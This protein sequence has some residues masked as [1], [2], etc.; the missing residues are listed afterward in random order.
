[1]PQVELGT[2]EVVKDWSK[3][4]QSIIGLLRAKQAA[5]LEQLE[6]SQH[7]LDSLTT[8]DEHRGKVRR[9]SDAFVASNDMIG[10]L[11][12]QVDAGNVNEATAEL[13]LF[14]AFKARFRP[15][16][17][18]L[19]DSYLQE[20]Q[21]KT[22]TEEDRD[23][24]RNALDQYRA[25]MFPNLENA[26]NGYLQRFN[27]GF[28]LRRLSSANIG[29]GSGSTSTYDVV[30]ND[31]PVNV[32]NSS[33]AA[34][35]VSFRNTLS[36]GD[37]N[38]LAL[39]IFFSSLDQDP[40][41][42]DKIVV[43]DDPMSSLDDHRSL[44]TVQEVRK[45]AQR[46]AQVIVLSHNKRFLCG[47]WSGADRQECLAIE[48]ARAGDASTI[49]A[50]DVNQDSI[51][52]HDQRHILLKG[53]EANQSGSKKEVAAAIRPHLEGYLRVA[54]PSDFPPGK[55]LRQFLQQCL[56]K[57]GAPE[58]VLTEAKIYELRD[59]IEFGNKFHHDTNPAWE[60]EGIDATEL[61]GFVKR[62]LTFVRPG[63]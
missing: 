40:N 57:V 14:R 52:E 36:A 13:N 43:I 11:K 60:S 32:R 9:V 25:D 23:E 46:A 20:K 15:D 28:T 30:I 38:A 5:P 54:C 22:Q 16:I 59:I 31:T 2:E 12:N 29:R 48:I 44:T 34:G 37:R 4:L 62:A 53:Y 8:Y 24:A 51:S 26:V 1:M 10:E 3:A 33:D 27:A 21:A 42:S 6:L 61:L 63:K 19:C 49:R 50:W 41:L 45:L 35:E 56:P 39:A 18:A 47:I 7:A 58:E 17:I 55:L